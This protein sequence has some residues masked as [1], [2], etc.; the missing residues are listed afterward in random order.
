VMRK[1]SDGTTK[2]EKLASISGGQYGREYPDS[3]GLMG[4][5]C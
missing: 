2:L 1:S 3:I 5:L 4:F